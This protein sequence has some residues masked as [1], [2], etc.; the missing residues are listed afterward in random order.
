MYLRYL[1][2]YTLDNSL[3]RLF[4]HH[5]VFQREL[6]Q[7]WGV[8]DFSK[9]GGGGLRESCD[10]NTLEN[11]SLGLAPLREDLQG[12]F[13]DGDGSGDVRSAPFL[14]MQLVAM[15]NT[16]EWDCIILGYC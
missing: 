16:V 13:G 15:V 10:V 1:Y 12:N 2:N 6:S 7:P 11:L 4:K 8:P 14:D 3:E 9:K 5:V